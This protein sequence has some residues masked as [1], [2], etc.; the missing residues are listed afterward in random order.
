MARNNQ[1]IE[2]ILEFIAKYSKENG[3]PPSIREIQDKFNFKSTST[4]SYYLKKLE[5]RGD[6]LNK[7]R[8]NRALTVTPTY[9]E[10][11]PDIL[12]KTLKDDFQL[13]PLIG[14]I[15]AGQPIL[16]QENYDESYL[17]PTNLFRNRG[18]DL[19]MLTVHGESMIDAGIFNGDKIVVRSQHT[20]ENGEIV[21]ALVENSATV[22]TYY[23]ESNRIRLQPENSSMQPMYFDNITILGKVIGLV[24]NL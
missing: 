7:G 12:A 11:H 1:K 8:K 14:T 16:A 24:R 4:V 2:H 5:S 15:A 9:Y 20:A 21:V 17:I 13:V 6:L 23:K 18:E 19:F 3:F 22:K 10:E